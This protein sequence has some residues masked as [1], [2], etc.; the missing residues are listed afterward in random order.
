MAERMAERRKCDGCRSKISL[1]ER[2]IR[3]LT[4]LLIESR[5]RFE[6]LVI[7]SDERFKVALET[8]R[9]DS[10]TGLL[11]R[12]GGEEALSRYFSILKRTPTKRNN[13]AILYLDL[14]RFKGINDTYGHSIGDEVLKFFTSK[15]SGVL[16]ESDIFARMG[17]DE[18][19]IILPG[20]GTARAEI[21]KKKIK[22]S[23]TEQQIRAGETMLSLSTS[24]G[25]A[26]ARTISGNV[27]H[28]SRVLKMADKSMY[29]DK[30]KKE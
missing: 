18:F 17:G 24:I 10:L 20:C 4:N 1:L 28:W 7:E 27:R 21:V 25:I 30:P 12:R 29:E 2:E 15:V 9:S 11:N 26:M 22:K 5:D 13:F 16:R 14:D 19:L 3:R 6:E 23:L 8:A